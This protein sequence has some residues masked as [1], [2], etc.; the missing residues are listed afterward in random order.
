MK[1]Y[2]EIEVSNAQHEAIQALRNK[3][4]P[5]HQVS[6]S[7]HKQLLH[8]RALQYH[9][10]QLIGYMGL[11]YRV[12]NVGG[13]VYKVLGVSDF[14]IDSAWQRKGIG[15]GMLAQLA[16]Y[17]RDKDVDFIILISELHDF[18][19]ANGFQLVESHASWLRIHEHTNYGVG[20]EYVDE[21]YVK[22]M[23]DKSWPAGHMDW[24]GYRY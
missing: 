4:F 17:A 23:K 16:D 10:N 14:C 24:L 12:V 2:P 3:A 22:P 11:D 7:Y 8:M 19:V 21:L 6:R 5:D 13:E 15:S 20:V 1:I 18:Y 9:D